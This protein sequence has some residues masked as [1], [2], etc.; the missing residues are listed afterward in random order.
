MFDLREVQRIYDRRA[1]GFDGFVSAASLGLHRAF[2]AAYARSLNVGPRDVVLDVGCGTG[3][4]FEHLPGRIVGV[5][6]SRGMLQRAAGRAML[7]QA[8]AA[9]LPFRDGA[10]D[11]VLSTYLVSTLDR[12]REAFDEMLRV[13]RPGRA[14][15]LS[16]D[17]LPPG[18][19]LGP[20]PM[21]ARLAR[22]GWS[23]AEDALWRRLRSRCDRPRRGAQLFGLL[24]WMSGLRKP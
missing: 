13:A 6:L 16:D 9:R 12:W 7:V 15:V 22:Y 19:F 21:F 4:D 10:F 8:D 2:R 18:W 1:S 23:S 24:F 3:L 11:G 17:R 20:G 5:D 14:V